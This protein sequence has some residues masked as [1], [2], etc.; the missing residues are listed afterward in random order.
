[1]AGESKARWQGQRL[2]SCDASGVHGRDPRVVGGGTVTA[3]VHL[4]TEE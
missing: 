4:A 2:P 3:E 1:M